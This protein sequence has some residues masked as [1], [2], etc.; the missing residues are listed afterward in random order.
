MISIKKINE[1]DIDLCYELDSNTISLWSKKQW[2][3]EFKKEGIRVFGVFFLKTLVGICVFHVVLDEAQINFFAVN[4]KYRK[5]GYGSHLMRY[6]IKQCEDSNINK[7]FLEVSQTN[8]IAE[9]FYSRFDFSTVG[10]RR[11]YYMD[12]SDALIKE[13]KLTT[14]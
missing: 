11:N 10:I 3:Q 14:K 1:K 12:G 13:K 2:A 9:K 7:L 6:L 8:A 4:Q 5:K